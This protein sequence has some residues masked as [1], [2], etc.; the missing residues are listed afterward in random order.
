MIDAVLLGSAWCASRSGYEQGMNSSN[1][2]RFPRCKNEAKRGRK[3]CGLHTNS[4]SASNPLTP[5]AQQPESP[6]T[7]ASRVAV[8]PQAQEP[9]AVFSMAEVHLLQTLQVENVRLTQENRRMNQLEADRLRFEQA[10]RDAWEEVTRLKEV[11][12]EL[13]AENVRLHGHVITL[14]TKKE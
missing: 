8:M 10:S 9:A 7:A 5:A 3:F 14:A 13:R 1:P 2:C 11:N 6:Q 4:D 12:D